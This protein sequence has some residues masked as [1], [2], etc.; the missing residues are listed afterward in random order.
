MKEN[1]NQ[2]TILG[3]WIYIMTDLTMFAGLFAAFA[4]LRTNTF[5]GVAARNIID[6]PFVLIE[7][8]LLLLSSFTC[9]I[10]VL[11][12]E[13]KRI[14]SMMVFLGFTFLLGGGFLAMEC[15]EFVHLF[16]QGNT[17]Q[18]SAFLSSYFSLVG[19]HGLHIFVGLFWLSILFVYL[20]RRGITESMMRKMTLFG[21]FWH[22]LDIVWI[23]I[24]TFVYLMGVL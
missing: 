5:G 12:A 9:G 11:F 18:R 7:T 20:L 4:V 6:L 15:S 17:P 19:T 21:I 8:F 14:K 16:A 22:F 3:F 10:A 24:F 1:K 2:K 23:F 13:W